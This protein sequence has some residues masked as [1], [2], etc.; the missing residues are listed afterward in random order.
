MRLLFFHLIAL[1]VLI[2][3]P[4]PASNKSVARVLDRLFDR[5]L[6][7]SGA[8]L[9][10]PAEGVDWRPVSHNFFF[11]KWTN[12][13]RKESNAHWYWLRD[14]SSLALARFS[15]KSHDNQKDSIANRARLLLDDWLKH[16]ATDQVTMRLEGAN[17]ERDELAQLILVL[18]WLRIAQRVGTGSKGKE[19]L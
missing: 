10:L 3:K 1:L 12:E 8:F 19:D 2:V 7:C 17:D 18:S 11:Q 6:N 4:V 15:G 13:A 5:D 14:S 9:H 16:L